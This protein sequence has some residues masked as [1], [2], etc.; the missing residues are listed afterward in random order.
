[1]SLESKI[2]WLINDQLTAIPNTRTFW[3]DLLENIKGLE[4]LTAGYTSFNLLPKKI[5]SM[6]INETKPDYIIRNASYFRKLDTNVRTISLVQDISN[7]PIQLDVINSS[8]VAIFNSPYTFSHY[9]DRVKTRVEIIPIGVDFNFFKPDRDYSSELGIS[10]D[11][12][13]FVGANNVTPKGI[14]LVTKIFENTKYN[15]CFV[16]K[17]N[18]KLKNNRAKIFNRVS[19]EMMF[20][21]YNSC[22]LLIC[23]SKIETQHLAGIEAAACNKPVVA[24]KVGSYY[25]LSDG[26]WGHLADEHT[27]IDKIDLVMKNSEKYSPRNFFLSRGFDK[28]N[29][30]NKWN[31]IIKEI[32]K[33]N[34]Y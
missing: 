21:I 22:K 7:D 10:K 23:T 32:C 14:D 26:E 12:I 25:D 16:M 31:Q 27:F 4:D 28:I 9:K 11:S 2:G 13:L 19:S 33:E 8:N 6:L 3:H 17:D 20:K 5:E 18:F 15:F 29:C 1:M 34:I 24:T 30:M